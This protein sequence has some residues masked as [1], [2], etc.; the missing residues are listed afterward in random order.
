MTQNRLKQ[1]LQNNL[2]L[3]YISN[4]YQNLINNKPFYVDSEGGCCET[5]R[6]IDL[7]MLIT[8]TMLCIEIDE[9]QHKKYIKFDENIRYDNLLMYFSGKC[10]FIRY[11]PDKVF[12]K[13]DT[14]K[15]PIFPKRINVLENNI[16]KHIQ[17]I[18]HALNTYF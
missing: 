3:Y 11:N 13:H 12:D 1:E 4:K 2:K 6:R 18:E 16:E 10:M 5:K 15:N 7:R 14:S 9:N 8:S 17:R